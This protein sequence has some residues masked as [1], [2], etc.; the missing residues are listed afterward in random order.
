MHWLQHC[1]WWSKPIHSCPI[2]ID[3]H[4]HWM[5]FFGSMLHESEL[6]FV[7]LKKRSLVP[8]FCSTEHPV[9]SPIRLKAHVTQF[10]ICPP[11][12][13]YLRVERNYEV[14]YSL[15]FKRR[16]LQRLSVLCQH[17][18][19]YL[20][21][22]IN[23]LYPVCW[24]HVLYPIQKVLCSGLCASSFEPIR[25][26]LSLDEPIA[27]VFLICDPPLFPSTKYLPFIWVD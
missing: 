24:A 16:L 18:W 3:L 13:V 6:D 20:I 14:T 22:Y 2:C 9:Q 11:S 5:T 19:T 7:F 8:H 4:R 15:P 10:E 1:C 21:K 26:I 12:K 27:Y 23:L 25:G 17:I